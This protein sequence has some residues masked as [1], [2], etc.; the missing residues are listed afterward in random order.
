MLKLVIVQYEIAYK[1]NPMFVWRMIWLNF[2]FSYFFSC[3]NGVS[4]RIVLAS[5][6]TRIFRKKKNGER[7]FMSFCSI[8]ENSNV[9]QK[10]QVFK[11][12][13][14][15]LLKVGRRLKTGFGRALLWW[16]LSCQANN[17]GQTVNLCESIN[18]SAADALLERFRFTNFINVL[19]YIYCWER[20]QSTVLT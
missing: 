15:D 1:L 7:F 6:F 13:N 5:D 8:Y 12:W 10:F 14:G 9:S 19:F 20:T 2:S 17:A 4:G 18:E 3:Q 16:L 11:K